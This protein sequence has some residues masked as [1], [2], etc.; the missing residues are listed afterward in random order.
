MREDINHNYSFTSPTND[1]GT[2]HVTQGE[3]KNVNVEGSND[4]LFFHESVQVLQNLNTGGR[5][6][7]Q[8]DIF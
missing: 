1:D 7:L 6:N 4:G 2:H 8:N 3:G 5:V